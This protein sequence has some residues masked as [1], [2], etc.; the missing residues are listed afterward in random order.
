[1]ARSMDGEWIVVNEFAQ[2]RLSIDTNGND[3]RLCIEDLA[4]E[5]RIYLDAFGL[6]GL[7]TATPEELT[8]YMDP[9]PRSET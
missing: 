2:V 5:R 9:N 7:T 3:P 4:T 6:A 8:R 1:M